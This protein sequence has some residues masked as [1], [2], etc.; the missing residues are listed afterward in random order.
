MRGELSAGDMGTYGCPPNCAGFWHSFFVV[1]GSED[2]TEG[3]SEGM[4][5]WGVQK[6]FM[7]ALK[8]GL[9]EEVRD[10]SSQTDRVSV[11]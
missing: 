2:M 9:C 1:A 4:S 5:Y 11:C 10:V 3:L 8:G 7:D 6:W